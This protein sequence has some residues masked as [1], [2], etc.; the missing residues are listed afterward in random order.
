MTLIG[1]HA[2]TVKEAQS[3]MSLLTI[4][5]TLLGGLVLFMDSVNVGDGSVWIP[6]FNAI[7]SIKMI[8]LGTAEPRHILFT[9]ASSLLYAAL[10]GVL[11]VRMLKSEKLLR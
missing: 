2:K 8:F 6:I 1:L 9:A 4:F 11:S 5:P 3:Q 7:I 10:L